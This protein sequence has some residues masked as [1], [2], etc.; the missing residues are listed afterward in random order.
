MRRLDDL[1]K[2]DDLSEAK[3]ASKLE[4]LRADLERAVPRLAVASKPALNDNLMV[5]DQSGDDQLATLLSQLL[6]ECKHVDVSQEILHGLKYEYMYERR[7]AVEHHHARTFEWIFETPEK[8]MQAKNMTCE[9][10]D[11]L[12]KSNG[13]FW[14]AGKAGSGKSTLMKFLCAD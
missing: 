7:S 4:A 2:R 11:W 12:K 13:I 9:F 6:R 10:S 14:L 5:A 3:L 1:N 8:L